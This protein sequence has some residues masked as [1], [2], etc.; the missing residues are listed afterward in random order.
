[1][2]IVGVI[3]ARGGSKRIPGKNIKDFCG[4]PLIA[5]T[6]EE[7]LK[8]RYMK[9]VVLSTDDPEIAHI[10]KAWGAEVPFMRPRALAED[11]TPDL[12]VFSHLLTEL[13]SKEK[14][15][16]EM[17]THL[18]V[19]GPLRTVDDMDKGIELLLQRTDYDS[20][21][22]V[23]PAPLHPLK[24]YK[25]EQ[26]RLTAFI[27]ESVYGIPEPYNAPVQSLPPAFA[28]AGYF[29]AM[30]SKTVIEK[31]LMTG[32][33]ILGYVCDEKNATDIDTPFDWMIAEAR[34]KERLSDTV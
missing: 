13:A 2:D 30:W 21:R 16:P 15:I 18:R 1:M 17:L 27:P 29:S 32:T 25:I 14:S 31:N 9:R 6:I 20:V 23:I 24:T 4:K 8:S 12:P 11:L 10:G 33:Q 5:W 28:S 22:A 26:G 7:A 3:I 34:M 19:T